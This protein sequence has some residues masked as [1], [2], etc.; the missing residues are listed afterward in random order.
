MM[1]VAALVTAALAP[2]VALGCGDGDGSSAASSGGGGT[3]SSATTSSAA[4]P[5][6]VSASSSTASGATSTGTGGANPDDPYGC[7]QGSPPPPPV[8]MPEGYRPWACWSQKPQCMVWIPDDP[9]TQVEPLEW[10]PCAPGS[11]GGDGCRQMKRPWWTDGFGI[12]ATFPAVPEL[13]LRGP[14]PLLRL[15]RESRDDANLSA[16]WFEWD[17]YELDGPA[18]FAPSPASRSLDA[19]PPS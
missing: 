11:P 18:R 14:R 8:P 7:L 1:P 6:S 17:V 12:A 2:L 4:G 9:A 19:R 13:D 16:W 5:V 15:A 3:S 10:E